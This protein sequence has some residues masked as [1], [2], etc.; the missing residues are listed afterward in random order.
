MRIYYQD[1]KDA[2]SNT[3]VASSYWLRNYSAA[4]ENLA[5]AA[6]CIVTLWI[7]INQGC[8]ALTFPAIVLLF[9]L[10]LITL[11]PTNVNASNICYVSFNDKVKKLSCC[12]PLLPLHSPSTEC[13]RGC[14]SGVR[15]GG[16]KLCCLHHHE[17]TS[18]N[19]GERDHPLASISVRGLPVPS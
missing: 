10:C 17:V 16:I 12:T 7:H 14:Q 11:S 2:S 8:G 9:R 18:K 1:L 19:T 4:S 15:G 3:P 13:G 5:V 6:P